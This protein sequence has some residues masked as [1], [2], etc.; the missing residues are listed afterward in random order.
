MVPNWNVMNIKYN[1][2]SFR[3]LFSK[4]VSRLITTVNIDVEFCKK[5]NLLRLSSKIMRLP[6]LISLPRSRQVG[7]STIT[8]HPGE[9]KSGQ[10]MRIEQKGKLRAMLELSFILLLFHF[11]TSFQQVVPALNNTFPEVGEKNRLPD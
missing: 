9:K 2:L 1:V 3:F 6:F 4:R 10:T 5:K 11:I 8:T 7:I